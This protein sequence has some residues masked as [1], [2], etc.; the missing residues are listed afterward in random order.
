MTP[1]TAVLSI[2]LLALSG[3]V[4]AQNPA[5][6]RFADRSATNFGVI[7]VTLTDG[8][9]GRICDNGFDNN[10]ASAVCA[11]L[12]FRDISGFKLTNVAA[13][14]SGSTTPVMAVT[15]CPSFLAT[16]P[17]TWTLSAACNFVVSTSVP[18]ACNNRSRD[19]AV[20]CTGTLTTA[21]VLVTT[22]TPNLAT[23]APT[24][25]SGS[26]TNLRLEPGP[27][28]GLAVIKNGS[29]ATA[30]NF[31]TICALGFGINEATT[32]CRMLCQNATTNAIGIT[33][34][35][36]ATSATYPVMISGLTCP[37]GATSTNGCTHNGWGVVA[38]GCNSTTAVTVR[39]TPIVLTP[40]AT[41]RASVICRDY[42]AFVF[43][44]STDVANASLLSLYGAYNAATCNFTKGENSS[45]VW[46][47]IPYIG[48]NT[49]QTFNDTHVIY[50]SYLYKN[51]TPVDGVYKDTPYVIPVICAI[52]KVGA[53]SAAVAPDIR[54]VTPISGGDTYTTEVRLFQTYSA[55]SFN[56]EITA[57]QKLIV[58]TKIYARVL[59]TSPLPQLLSV[60]SCRASDK[61]DGTGSNYYIV[62]NKCASTDNSIFRVDSKTIGINF[63]VISFTGTPSTQVYVICDVI[64]CT[65]DDA[66]PRC[67][68]VCGTPVRKRR[69]VESAP[70][71]RQNQPYNGPFQLVYQTAA[72]GRVTA[73]GVAALA[74][75]SLILALIPFGLL[76]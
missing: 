29:V 34:K 5:S 13:V 9:V 52:P 50:T 25:C 60:R 28:E 1:S 11:M 27:E 58:G 56:S 72:A 19:V 69:A 48:C 65:T 20:I 76:A 46:A 7:E 8:T 22:V 68:Q 17:T 73:A 4:S 31:G 18:P 30:T 64:T 53:V 37:A 21:S 49:V 40:P 61:T 47:L 51:V 23:V 36:M 62:E 14:T 12:G 3:T 63:V 74:T 71:V 59:L 33:G 66:S 55:G 35:Y 24:N 45:T 15:G 38:P 67:Q 54:T 70:S 32:I 43:L 26:V 57:G 44:P 41:P 39:C 2:C 42:N 10:G 6:V 16:S 75:A